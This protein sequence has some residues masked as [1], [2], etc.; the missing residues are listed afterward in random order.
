MFFFKMMVLRLPAYDQRE[1]FTRIYILEK[2]VQV[3]L[4]RFNNIYQY[5]K[6]GYG[7]TVFNLRNKPLAY[8]CTRSQLLYCNIFFAALV[9]DPVPDLDQYIIFHYYLTFVERG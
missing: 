3:Y 1:I 8:V 5:N 2:Y 6:R 9:F 4:E 7:A